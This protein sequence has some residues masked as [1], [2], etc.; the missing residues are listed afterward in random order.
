MKIQDEKG[1]FEAV[2]ALEAY[3][4]DCLTD[5]RLKEKTVDNE[6]S[7]LRQD[8]ATLQN[9]S[10]YLRNLKGSWGNAAQTML[11]E[12]PRNSTPEDS[13]NAIVSILESSWR[14]MRATD[15][16]EYAHSRKLIVSTNGLP[17]VVSIVSNQL[18]RH[19]PDTFVSPGWGWWELEPH[20]KQSLIEQRQKANGHEQSEPQAKPEQAPV[21]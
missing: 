5:L 9:R 12:A 7:K 17:G 21:H 13:F 1:A 3:L 14:K 15:I 2:T 16:A 6:L 10:T 4:N 18:S 19:S 20:F 8:I 11:P